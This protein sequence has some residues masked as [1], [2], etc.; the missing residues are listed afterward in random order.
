MT[1][2]INLHCHYCYGPPVKTYSS[3]F[4]RDKIVFVKECGHT[5][6]SPYLP[7][8][9]ERVF[10]KYDEDHGYIK[11]ENPEGERFFCNLLCLNKYCVCLK[12]GSILNLF[13]CMNDYDKNCML[14]QYRIE[15]TNYNAKYRNNIYDQKLPLTPEES[16][17]ESSESEEEDPEIF[18]SEI[19][20]LREKLRLSQE[21]NARHDKP[22]MIYTYMDSEIKRLKK[23][24]Q[25][26]QEENATLKELVKTIHTDE[27]KLKETSDH[28]KQKEIDKLK[29][30]DREIFRLTTRIIELERIK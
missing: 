9:L 10:H 12:V 1:L 24:L 20:E 27:K 30:K 15:A 25:E 29:E 8:M 3:G 11:L 7:S 2:R 22:L 26:C 14:E 4:K 18:L 21:E 19:K 28:K 5:S 13:E 23:E 6:L 16:T 17:N